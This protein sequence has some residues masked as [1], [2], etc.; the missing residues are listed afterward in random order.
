MGEP[1]AVEHLEKLKVGD[2][3]LLDRGY[4]ARW[5]VAVLNQAGIHFCMRVDR[6]GKGG[7][8]ARQRRPSVQ[9]VCSGRPRA[10]KAVLC[11]D[12]AA[13]AR[14]FL[15]RPPAQLMLHSRLSDTDWTLVGSIKWGRGHSNECHKFMT[16]CRSQT[17]EFA[18]LKSHLLMSIKHLL[19]IKNHS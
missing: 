14:Y 6:S 4:Q 19:A 15:G 2:V 7:L 13:R 10:D 8:A 11:Y 9:G 1:S 5:F 3:L 16:R 18:S 12:A 17:H